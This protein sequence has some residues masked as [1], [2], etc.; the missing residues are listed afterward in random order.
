M[1]MGGGGGG[2]LERVG[3][4]IS[5]GLTCKAGWRAVHAAWELRGGPNLDLRHYRDR[6]GH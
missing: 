2:V 1:M 3:S 5:S 4:T 6:A